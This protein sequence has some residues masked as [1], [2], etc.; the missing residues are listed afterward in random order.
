M[1]PVAV[2]FA[3]GRCARRWLGSTFA[4][5]R[6]PPCPRFGC[7]PRSH[8]A[9]S[10]LKWR[11]SPVRSPTAVTACNVRAS[12]RNFRAQSHDTPGRPA[13]RGR[14]PATRAHN[15]HNAHNFPWGTPSGSP[16]A[17]TRRR[18][19]QT[20]RANSK[21]NQPLA[22]PVDRWERELHRRR[23]EF[24]TA[25]GSAPGVPVADGIMKF[26]SDGVPARPGSRSRAGCTVGMS[27]YSEAGSAREPR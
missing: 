10:S 2:S 19:N 18:R 3:H 24:R 4:G 26:A 27:R 8:F 13:A 20:A 14:Y 6:A 17:S 23:W 1:G 9:T 7:R 5:F 22:V 21:G 11:S 25:P 15:P 16:V 12:L